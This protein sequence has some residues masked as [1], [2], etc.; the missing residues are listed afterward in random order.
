MC[1]LFFFWPLYSS[2]L[3]LLFGRS[4]IFSHIQLNATSG[5]K[6]H[7]PFSSRSIFSHIKAPPHGFPFLWLPFQNVRVIKSEFECGLLCCC[8][9]C[10]SSLC[11][12]P[13]SSLRP[14]DKRERYN[15]P[16]H[17]P[18]LLDDKEDSS[19]QEQHI[20]L[21]LSSSTFTLPYVAFVPTISPSPEHIAESVML[22]SVIP[23]NTAPSDWSSWFPS[24]NAVLGICWDQSSFFQH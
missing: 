24:K 22:L 12:V 5:T 13:E 3:C 1:R 6:H 8:F 17:C 20:S 4:S 15:G 21:S 23:K 2:A 19:C 14:H 18:L 9:H 11:L 16:T 10:P 7:F